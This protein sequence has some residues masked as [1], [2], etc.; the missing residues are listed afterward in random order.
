MKL[1][2]HFDEEG[3]YIEPIFEHDVDRFEIPLDRL[4]E[5]EPPNYIRAKFYDGVWIEGADDEYLETIKSEPEVNPI[6]MIMEQ[7]AFLSFELANTQTHLKI[8]QEQNALLMQQQSEIL[9]LLA[10]QSVNEPVESNP[11]EDDQP[12]EGTE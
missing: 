2:Y 9:L 10:E 7:N 3:F 1:L 11:V 8:T 4:T 6:D 12:E 5:L